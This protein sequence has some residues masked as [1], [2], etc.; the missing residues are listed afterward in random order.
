MAERERPEWAE[1]AD[2]VRERDD[3]KIAGTKPEALDHLLV[4]DLSSRNMG[5]CYC[6]SLLA[7]L[8]AE[9]IRIE[10]PE[11]DFARTF[12]PYGIT[13]MGVGLAYLHEGRNKHHITL[14]LETP[15]GQKMLKGLVSRADVLIETYK[16]GVMDNWG[17]GYE[18]LSKINPRLIYTSF[19]TY[20][21]FGAKSNCGMP[22]Y[23]NVDEALAHVQYATGEILPP[24]KTYDDMPWAVPTKAGNWLT[25]YVAGG[26]AAISILA[27]LHYR[28]LTER[29]RPSTSRSLRL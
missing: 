29:G 3:P 5:G 16:P 14:N 27:A 10:P 2:W 25:W 20:G 18:E 7:E 15:E 11:G 9:T 23:N 13:H 19:Y 8:G 1:W 12:T 26:F 17:I 21:Q 4:L 24:G 6:S 28:R 22:D